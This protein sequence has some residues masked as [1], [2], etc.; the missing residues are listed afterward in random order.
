MWISI[1]RNGL[2]VGRIFEIL[3]KFFFGFPIV[4]QHVNLT[5]ITCWRNE[6]FFWTLFQNV[7]GFSRYLTSKYISKSNC[8]LHVG[9][10]CKKK[11]HFFGSRFFKFHRHV[12]HFLCKKRAKKRL[13]VVI[14]IKK[15]FRKNE[16]NKKIFSNFPNMWHKKSTFSRNFYI[17]VIL[18]KMIQSFEKFHFR[19]FVNKFIKF[20]IANMKVM[21]F[22][23]VNTYQLSS[24]L[25]LIILLIIY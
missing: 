2:L 8:V 11:N 6:I 4:H 14:F 7:D 12:I 22:T 10:F 3:N 9:E 19:C 1:F 18:R 16:K 20:S 25:P 21:I 23:T 15:I 17:W 24:V 13:P 5:I